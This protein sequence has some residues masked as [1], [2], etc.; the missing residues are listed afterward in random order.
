M[1]E[2]EV[3]FCPIAEAAQL[4]NR[5]HTTWRICGGRQGSGTSRNG[6][7]RPLHVLDTATLGGTICP[8]RAMCPAMQYMRTAIAQYLIHV[9]PDEVSA[10]DTQ[11]QGSENGNLQLSPTQIDALMNFLSLNGASYSIRR[12]KRASARTQHLQRKPI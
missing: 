7:I 10:T 1:Q 5:V 4:S 2:L 11:R 12:V 8:W 3:R 6:R 9:C